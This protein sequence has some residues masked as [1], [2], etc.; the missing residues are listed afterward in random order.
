MLFSG[1]IWINMVILMFER[2]MQHVPFY[3][4]TNGSLKH[5]FE[6]LKIHNQHFNLSAT[7]FLQFSVL[8]KRNFERSKQYHSN[9][10]HYQ[11]Q[12]NHMVDHK[13]ST[14]QKCP[15]QLKIKFCTKNGFVFQFYLIRSNRQS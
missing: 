9:H 8:K 14:F 12:A 15:R 4:G 10:Q 2:F 13:L 1:I 7:L 11:V 5:G 6:T 3:K